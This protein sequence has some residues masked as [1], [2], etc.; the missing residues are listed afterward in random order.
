LWGTKAAA[1]LSFECWSQPLGA[2]ATAEVAK[3]VADDGGDPD[4]YDCNTG[5]YIPE[6]DEPY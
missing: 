2:F 3:Q 5:K 1:L 6:P 4:K